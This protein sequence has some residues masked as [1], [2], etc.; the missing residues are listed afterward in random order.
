MAI[1]EWTALSDVANLIPDA[2]LAAAPDPRILSAN[3]A[4][5]ALFGYSADA[6]VGRPLGLLVDK[7]SGVHGVGG[8]EA[9][10]S[11]PAS[12][13]RFVH[14]RG[15]R[16]D[17]ATSWAE[18]V[19][20]PAGTDEPSCASSPTT[21]TG[22]VVAGDAREA[23]E[24][25]DQHAESLDLVLTDVVMPEMSGPALAERLRASRPDLPV[26]L[27]SGY[28]EPLVSGDMETALPILEKPFSEDELL[29]KV[30][31]T[32]DQAAWQQ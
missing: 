11:G 10:F 25:F 14:V 8:L 4:T 22:V 18:A 20:Q 12:S 23:M 21:G 26:L 5:E 7:A 6:V 1:D 31:R 30:R 32:L 13:P 9:L 27:M 16:Q 3:S 2:V 29:T 19:A 15:R 28:A 24:V 17:G